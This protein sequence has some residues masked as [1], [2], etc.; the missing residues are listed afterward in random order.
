MGSFVEPLSGETAAS[1]LHAEG[2]AAWRRGK[3][4]RARALMAEALGVRADFVPALTALGAIEQSLG[5]SAAAVAALRRAQALAPSERVHS[6]NL[7]IALTEAGQGGEAVDCLRNAIR[8][9]GSDADLLTRLGQALVQRGETSEGIRHLRAAV[10]AMPCAE[11]W[12][13]LGHA[14]QLHDSL[15]DA[16]AAYLEALALEPQHARA[17]QNLGRAY[18]DSGDLNAAEDALHR[19]ATISPATADIFANLAV[20]RR[21]RGDLDGALRLYQRAMEIEPGNARVRYN[22][23]L[24]LLLR[25]DLSAGWLAQEARRDIPSFPM[26][27]RDAAQPVWDG[28]ALGGRRLLVHAEQGLGD[29]LQFIRYL[30]LIGLLGLTA[31]SRVTLA[32]QP[33]LVSLLTPMAGVHHVVALGSHAAPF[34][35]HV[36]LLSLPYLVGTTAERIPA[37]VP[38]I[39]PS[40]LDAADWRGRLQ[41]GGVKI[42]FVW[43]G[44]PGHGNDRRRSLSAGF[45]RSLAADILALDQKIHLFGFQLGHRAGDLDDL[46]EAGRYRSLA[47]ELTSFGQTAAAIA[48]MDLVIG[49]DTSVVHLAGA[50]A[51]RTLV[52]LGSAP[53]WRWRTEGSETPWYPTLDLCRAEPLADAA[54]AGGAALAWLRSWLAGR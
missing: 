41:A 28:R 52:L 8:L 20:I 50:M 25:G 33:E 34:D 18:S 11:A 54:G 53:D 27:L 29:T 32:V 22:M 30:P 36:P 35:V 31:G 46:R 23:G 40:A 10:I 17:L 12:F 6:T 19:A 37:A 14:L 9:H 43:A 13:L 39:L 47:P 15:P 49:V 26:A 16:V 24:T 44:N 1:M 5:E 21:R 48:G 42:G 2:I 45:A 51:A 4:G 38:Y 3:N 7:A